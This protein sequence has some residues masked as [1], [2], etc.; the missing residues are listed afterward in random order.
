MIKKRLNR[1]QG[2]DIS[3]FVF[4]CIFAFIMV[5]PL[6]FSISSAF[7]PLNE[8][9]IFPPRFLPMRP[10]IQNFKDLFNLMSESWIPFSRYVF[11]TMFITTVGTAGHIIF[12]ALCAYPLAIYK[13][14]GS[15]AFYTL[16][17]LALMFSASVTAIPN[18]LTMS[19]IGWVDTYNAIII[20]YFSA[21]LGLFLMKPFIEQNVPI[22]LIESAKVDGVTE[23]NIFWRIAMPLV[24]PAWLTLMVF[25]VQ[26]LWG[27]GPSN[28]IY[29][30]QLKSLNYAM[31][32][33]VSG[34]IARAGAG[35]AVSVIMMVVPITVFI[36]TQSKVVE[37][38]STSG[39][40]E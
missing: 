17:L 6:L 22:S 38:M 32:Q 35:A 27:M 29:S 2:V 26:A 30:E 7:K 36:I 15:K 10:T 39:I 18:Y 8:Q 34:G 11:N 37:T 24:K 9:F 23:W 19:R 13:F 1:S 3:I 21:P 31:G 12:A 4:L 33:I 25:S 20:P 40:K 28:F 16:I 5:L 14:P